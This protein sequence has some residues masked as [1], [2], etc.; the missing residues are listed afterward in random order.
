M[1][2]YIW[3]TLTLSSTWEH[4]L[5]LLLSHFSESVSNPWNRK[6]MSV[7]ACGYNPHL[8]RSKT[9]MAWQGILVKEN[10]FNHGEQEVENEGKSWGRRFTLLGHTS[11]LLT[12]SHFLAAHLAMDSSVI[13]PLMST[14][15]SWSNHLSKALCVNRRVW[16]ES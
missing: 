15:P 16:D 12:K 2:L 13:N 1:E 10:C 7:L 9:E 3:C 4:S 11:L 5:C 6:E 8:T 14:A